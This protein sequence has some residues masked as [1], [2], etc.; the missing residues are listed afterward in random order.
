MQISRK[1]QIMQEAVEIVSEKGLNALTM[2]TLSAKVGVTE[3]ALYRHFSSKNELIMDIL[4]DIFLET[5]SQISEVNSRKQPNA[6]KLQQIM[7]NQLFIF[8]QRPAIANLLFAEE[9][10]L[11]NHD[12]KIL[13]Y[14][15][16]NTIQLYIQEIFEAGKNNGEFKNHIHP[17]HISLMFLG[18]IRMLVMNWKL[19][20]YQW[21][22]PIEGQVFCQNLLEI[23]EEKNFNQ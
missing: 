17:R 3:G 9:Y 10:F 14:S 5:T 23:I 12:I 19:S 13:I 21:D 11:T 6:A 16:I 4:N 7:E 18:T 2:S 8:K 20:N 1:K 15:I 22:L